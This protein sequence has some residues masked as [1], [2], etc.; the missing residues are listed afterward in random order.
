MGN[1]RPGNTVRTAGSLLAV[2]VMLV[3][4]L[5]HPS[6][7]GAGGSYAIYSNSLAAGW[8][9]GS[10]G[11][12]VTFAV[13]S[14]LYAGTRPISFQATSGWGGLELDAPAKFNTSVYDALQFAVYAS[15]PNLN[16][17]VYAE[18]AAYK[19]LGSPVALSKY[20]GTPPSGAWKL[21]TVPLADLGAL[22][23]VVG[24][25]TIQN[26]S[27][28][29]IPVIYVAQVSMVTTGLLTPVPTATLT[30]SNTPTSVR[31]ATNT[32]AAT[33]T[34]RPTNTPPPAP[35]NTPSPAPTSESGASMSGLHVVGNTIRNG[36][37]QVVQ[38]RGVN[39]SSWEYAC[40]DGS[41]DTHD[42]TADQTEVNAMKSWKINAV[43]V[44]L[45]EDC[46]LGIHGVTVGGPAYQQAIVNYVNLLA[47]NNIAAI[48][49]LHFNGTG[50]SLAVEQE[51][52]P[53]RTNSP[54]FWTSVAA[55]FKG[56]S[57]VLFEPYNEPYP[58]NGNDTTAAWKCWRDGG[59]CPGVSFTVAGMQEIVTAIRNAGAP[60]PIILTGNNWGS[61]MTQWKAY[62]PSD[63]LNQLVAGWHT[64]GDGLDCQDSACWTSLIAGIAAS[65]PIVATE[66]GEFDCGHT[67]I[68]QVMSFLD[69]NNSGYIAWAWGPYSCG[70]E[71]GLLTN[72]NGSPTAYGSGFRDH[73]LAR[74]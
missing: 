29:A 6:Q 39:R 46:W 17:S 8:A 22:N 24:D 2:V 53:D 36:S 59:T 38:L 33:A 58:D 13:T 57:N 3:V 49:N 14:P 70:S 25:F 18:S 68:D 52:M 42:G 5:T 12:Q 9:N 10:Y 67:Y 71:P 15:A 21:Y 23:R 40:F 51:P 43:R 30:P 32:P 44:T 35:T 65:Y 60:Q 20:G 47:A 69:T 16:L 45:N 41:G 26:N 54:S 4:G 74:P 66:I 19:S 63:P 27:S 1:L 61:Q 7:A 34:T 56:S 73:L 55:T 11:S 50:T 62:L 28:R 31:T 64:Y 48:V 37:N 72:W